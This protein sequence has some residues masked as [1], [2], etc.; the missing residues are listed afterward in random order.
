M[1]L[2]HSQTAESTATIVTAQLTP[3]SGRHLPPLI[4]AGTSSTRGSHLALDQKRCSLGRVETFGQILDMYFIKISNF[5]TTNTMMKA[6][7]SV[8]G[9]RAA[10]IFRYGGGTDVRD[11]PPLDASATSQLQRYS[12]LQSCHDAA[13]RASAAAAAVI[14]VIQEDW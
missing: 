5:S 10:Q 12:C 8:T 9:S 4:S 11:V 3:S 2:Q 13:S 6:S 1:W 14:Q 7:S